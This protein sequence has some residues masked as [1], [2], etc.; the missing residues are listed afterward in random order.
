MRDLSSF[1][2]HQKRWN[3][4]CIPVFEADEQP[5]K[6]HTRP[7]TIDSEVPYIGSTE[8]IQFLPL[9][10]TKSAPKGIPEKSAKS[11]LASL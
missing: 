9:A 11:H 3:T 8:K 7:Q 2:R 1:S 6:I 10:G 5:E 4:G